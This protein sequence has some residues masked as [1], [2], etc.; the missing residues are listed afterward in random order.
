MFR[1]IAVTAFPMVTDVKKSHLPKAPLPTDTTESG[2]LMDSN[3]QKIKAP[4]PID[5][6]V[7]GMLTAVRSVQNSKASAPIDLTVYSVPE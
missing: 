5:V 1:P 3:A 6:T 7:S 4:T 2:M